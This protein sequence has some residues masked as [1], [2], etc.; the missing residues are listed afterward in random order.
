MSKTRS[1]TPEKAGHGRKELTGNTFSQGLPS[2]QQYRT[3]FNLTVQRRNGILTDSTQPGGDSMVS[4][5]DCV[6]GG[7]PKTHVESEKVV[8]V[9][10]DA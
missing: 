8:Y 7:L 4:V 1:S 3:D 9:R 10:H 5:V 6:S 2:R